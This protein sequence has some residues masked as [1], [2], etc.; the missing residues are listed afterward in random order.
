MKQHI[1]VA[2]VQFAYKDLANL[3]KHP[4]PFDKCC[5]KRKSML[6]E[7]HEKDENKTKEDLIFF[8]FSFTMGKVTKDE[9]RYS[10]GRAE[11]S[12]PKYVSP[13]DLK[14]I[15]E[16]S[17]YKNEE[18]KIRFKPNQKDK[19]SIKDVY[20]KVTEIAPNSL[21]ELS[22]FS[23]SHYIG[24]ILVNSDTRNPRGKRDPSDK[25][26]R[27]SDFEDY[28]MH[29]DDF[30]KFRKAFNPSSSVRIWG[31][32]YYDYW[33]EILKEIVKHPL[34]L[35]YNG[36][37]G[38]EEVFTLTNLSTEAA[39]SLEDVVGKQNIKEYNTY[40]T[41]NK[42]KKNIKIKFKWL[43]YYICYGNVEC[44]PYYICRKAEIKTY[45]G[46]IGTQSRIDDVTG[47]MR[48]G[49]S[50]AKQLE[51]YKKSLNFEVEKESGYGVFYP[52]KAKGFDYER[53]EIIP[54]DK[55]GVPPL[56]GRPP[57]TVQFT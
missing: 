9:I 8:T 14:P 11:P 26:A 5:E 48:V 56:C 44:Y 55:R 53:V 6:I 42:D 52:P 18:G 13:L 12:L 19:M 49:G 7:Q 45:G 32:N 28:N 36:K 38:G 41:Y 23:H 35:R 10:A 3:R 51:F 30:V 34:Y 31:C 16:L 33:G 20:Q 15:T 25:D 47:L 27:I 40:N 39:E 37:V 50:Y 1:L 21:W 43:K 54:P 2:G 22:I 57:S 29:P 4:Q 24:P 17:Y 46:L